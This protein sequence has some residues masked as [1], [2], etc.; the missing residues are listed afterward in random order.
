MTIENKV[1]LIIANYVFLVH[2]IFSLYFYFLL[3]ILISLVTGNWVNLLIPSALV[4]IIS[5][6]L[7][8]IYCSVRHISSSLWKVRVSSLWS[9][10][11]RKIFS[12]KMLL[13]KANKNLS[14]CFQL[15]RDMLISIQTQEWM[16][17][18]ETL[19][20]SFMQWKRKGDNIYIY[21]YMCMYPDRK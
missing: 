21:V 6:M 3:D 8:Q 12:S 1:K 14:N 10:K 13:G 19:M 18:V 16:H 20:N 5:V 9:S 15:E 2:L 17:K 4:N 7:L 11:H